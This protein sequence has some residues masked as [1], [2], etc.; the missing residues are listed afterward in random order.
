[1]E[2]SRNSGTMHCLKM[3]LPTTM[4]CIMPQEKSPFAMTYVTPPKLVVDLVRLPK[5]I[6]V[7]IAT[8]LLMLKLCM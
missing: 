2:I 1:M 8:E 7:S 4:L 6:G 3:S 5:G